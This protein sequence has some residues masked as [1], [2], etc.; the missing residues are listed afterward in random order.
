IVNNDTPE[1]ATL[2]PCR[3][4][5]LQLERDI[6]PLADLRA[7]AWLW[8]HF[9]TERY[10]LVHTLTPK[11]GLLGMLA[12]RWA[13][14]PCR[15]HTFTGQVWA[16]RTGPMRSLLKAADRL[17]SISATQVL[18][19]SF[20]Q[21]DF[22][23]TQ[24]VVDTASI[25]VL[26]LGSVAGVDANRFRPDAA[27]REG[28]RARFL[29]PDAATLFLYLGRLKRD[30][31]VLDL[32]RAFALWSEQDPLSSLLLVGPD[33]EGL[34]PEIEQACVACRDRL[35]IAGF[36]T[37]PERYLAASDVLCL[38]SYREG[39]GVVILEPRA[40]LP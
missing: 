23:V 19:D 32:A 39:F 27:K 21:R 13:R 24:G 33:E 38:P 17:I 1:L 30:K 15:L 31:G 5:S 4:I 25:G 10:E 22:L 3:I 40:C 9:R 12:A 7:L 26:G 2:L 29:I 11:A 6:A 36:S 18:A 37:E 14:V 8:R 35:H 20:S 16:S 28:L 34:L